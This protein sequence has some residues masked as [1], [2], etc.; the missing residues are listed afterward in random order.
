MQ[1]TKLIVSGRVQGV[2]FRS[3]TTM[4]ATQLQLTGTVK[5]KVDGTVEIIVQ[6]TDEDLNKFIKALKNDAFNRFA[7]IDHIEFIATYDSPPMN[8]F[9]TIY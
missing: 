7:R 2:G 8:D 4:I 1:T 9:Q 6:A 5:N 3:T